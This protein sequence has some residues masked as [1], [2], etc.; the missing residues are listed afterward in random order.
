MTASIKMSHPKGD[1]T[2][3]IDGADSALVQ[4]VEA[5]IRA[6]FGQPPADASLTG[7]VEALLAAARKKKEKELQ[8]LVGD[9]PVFK[10]LFGDK[11]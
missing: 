6:V 4:H 10:H 1:I 3:T 5:K 2:I 9:N 8:D 11:P 7:T